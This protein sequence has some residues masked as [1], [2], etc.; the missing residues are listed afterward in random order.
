MPDP[1][2][3]C[4][5]LPLVQPAQAQKHVTLN[6]ALLRLDGL[7][8]LTLMSTTQATPPATV[9]EGTAWAVPSGAVN[10]WA[11]QS[12]RIAIGSNGGWTFVT[13]RKGWR[14]HDLEAG[15]PLIHD[16]TAWITGAVTMAGSGAGLS[17]RVAEAEVKITAGAS[18]TSTLVI[19]AYAMVVGATARVTQAITGTATSWSLGTAGPGEGDRFGSG[20]GIGP[21]SWG[22][23]ILGAPLTYYQPAPL[24]LTASGGSFSAGRVRIALHWWEIRLPA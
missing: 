5:G 16:G 18:V 4:L 20:L 6:E 19:P 11:G 15:A 12:G 17:A 8:N 1:I 22:R 2:S 13:P 10:A 23:G 21:G 9:T 24:I 14:A 3:P 7:V